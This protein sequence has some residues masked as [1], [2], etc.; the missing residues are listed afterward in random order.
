MKKLVL[1]VVAVLV[2]LFSVSAMNVSAQT[3]P[4][5]LYNTEKINGK[6]ISKEVCKMDPSNLIYKLHLKY[7]YSYDTNDRL[8][9]CK[10]LRWNDKTA[11][12]ENDHILTYEYNNI[13]NTVILNYAIWNER[14]NEFESPTERAEY[15]YLENNQLSYYTKYEKESSESDWEIKTHFAMNNYFVSQLG[16]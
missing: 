14:M 15:Q 9:S 10:T 13:L 6:V 12:W 4:E 1:N 8:K 5:F 2:S 3:S 7:E 16:K 11:V